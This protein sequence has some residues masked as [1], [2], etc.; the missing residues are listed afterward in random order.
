MARNGTHSS[1]KA[2]L[3]VNPWSDLDQIDDGMSDMKRRNI[4]S[5]L[6]HMRKNGNIICTDEGRGR[7]YAVPGTE[8]P[9]GIPLFSSYFD[10]S[11]T[12]DEKEVAVISEESVITAV[13][14]WLDGLRP[15]VRPLLSPNDIRFLSVLIKQH[16]EAELNE[17]KEEEVD[18][19]DP[20]E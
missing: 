3:A 8:H 13:D 5:A 11:T 12:P 17:V 14:E 2:W 6:S 16:C 9:D 20:P 7:S 1:I 18:A 15:E 4:S 19:D 10:L